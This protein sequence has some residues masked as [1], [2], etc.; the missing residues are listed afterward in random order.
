[1][2]LRLMPLSSNAK[3][4]AKTI[5]R[6]HTGF[7]GSVVAIKTAAPIVV[8]TFDDGPEPGGTDRVLAALANKNASATFFV[9][10][11]RVRRYGALLDEVLAAG[12]EVALHGADHQ[13][14]T[15]F[16][17]ADAK[18]RTGAARAELEDRAGVPVRWFRP[19]YGSQTPAT[20]A[21]VKQLGL[22]PVMWGLTTWDWRDVP[23]ADRVCKAQEGLRRG[24]ILLAHDAFAG[25]LDGVPQEVAPVLDRGDLVERVLSAYGESGLV[26]RS[27]R[28]ALSVGTLEKAAWFAG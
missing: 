5:I 17:Y 24:A 11:S 28:D 23:Q 6:K 13:A 18:R 16:G 22:M 25:V 15:T 12:H 19:P 21:A 4:A 8:I 7:V 1:M 20:W 26:G 14:L 3:N 2:R 9:L 27:L 10:L